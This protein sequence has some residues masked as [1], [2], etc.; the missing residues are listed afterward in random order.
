MPMTDPPALLFGP[1]SPGTTEY[2]RRAGLRALACLVAAYCGSRHDAVDRLRA[3]E[4]V[5][6]AMGRALLAFDRVPALRRR[7]VLAT[8]A[9]VMR[10]LREEDVS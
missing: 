2:D 6:D 8:Y 4:A 5:P 1:W 10:P 7:Q 9:A 3:A